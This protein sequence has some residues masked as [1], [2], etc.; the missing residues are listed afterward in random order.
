MA[1]PIAIIN[2]KS[3]MGFEYFGTTQLAAGESCIVWTHGFPGIVSVLVTAAAEVKG[4]M[5]AAITDSEEVIRADN[6]TALDL[7]N[8]AYV[9]SGVYENKWG[10]SAYRVKNGDTSD[11]ITVNWRIVR[12]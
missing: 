10:V 1:D 12:P 9:V 2:R 5:V 11:T 7:A 6:Y 3:S 4:Y 8:E